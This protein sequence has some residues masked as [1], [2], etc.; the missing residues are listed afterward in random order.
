MGIFL[1]TNLSELHEQR[2]QLLEK[3]HDLRITQAYHLFAYS[4]DEITENPN[5]LP[6]HEIEQLVA[7]SSTNIMRMRESVRD[8]TNRISVL[9]PRKS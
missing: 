1:S 4:L 3:L 7:A 2:R 5:R 8:I 6:E 9:T